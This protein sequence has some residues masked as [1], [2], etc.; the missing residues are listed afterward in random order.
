MLVQGLKE[1]WQE[2]QAQLPPGESPTRTGLLGE[3]T[4]PHQ[5]VAPA[6]DSTSDNASLQD[7][8]TGMLQL[9]GSRQPA[10]AADSE[11]SSHQRSSQRGSADGAQDS[12]QQDS[13][14]LTSQTSSSQQPPSQQADSQASDSQG[15]S[16][17]QDS[18]KAA[19]DRMQV[20]QS[21]CQSTVAN[22]SPMCLLNCTYRS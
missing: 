20:T 4:A 2:R 17:V 9:L 11:G 6:D 3:A 13:Q 7:L 1:A 10:A 22:T 21:A 19:Y 16:N 12:T 8:D 15:L 5:G 14:Q 18:Q